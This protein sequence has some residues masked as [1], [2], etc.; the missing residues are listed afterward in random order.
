MER[1]NKLKEVNLSSHLIRLFESIPAYRCLKA[2]RSE[3][4]A[5]AGVAS[6]QYLFGL[7]VVGQGM[8]ICV[9]HSLFKRKRQDTMLHTRTHPISQPI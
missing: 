2:A 8:L 1:K 9:C 7:A 4:A 5:D 3:A 6:D